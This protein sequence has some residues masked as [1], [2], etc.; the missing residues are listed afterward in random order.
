VPP[1]KIKEAAKIEDGKLLKRKLKEPDEWVNHAGKTHQKHLQA[2]TACK[3][4]SEIV[5]RLLDAFRLSMAS[6]GD[7][8]TTDKDVRMGELYTHKALIDRID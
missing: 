6:S 8:E 4:L 5:W 3:S 2:F 7:P 1:E